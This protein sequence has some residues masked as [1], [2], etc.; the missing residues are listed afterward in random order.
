MQAIEFDAHLKDGVIRLPTSYRHWREGCPVKVIILADDDEARQPE[1]RDTSRRL[2]E[3]MA[4]SRRCATS[5]ELD[6]RDAD[7]IIGYDLNGLPT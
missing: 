3:I 7:Q 5:P 4:V 6:P 1:P 2:A